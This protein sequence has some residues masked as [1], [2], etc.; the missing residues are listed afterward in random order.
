[1]SHVPLRARLKHLEPDEQD[2]LKDWA[3]NGLGNPASHG[4]YG[5]W[6]FGPRQHGTSHIAACATH[7]LVDRVAAWEHIDALVLTDNIRRYWTLE[8]TA[9]RN[10]DDYGLFLDKQELETKL[11]FL[12][13]DC[14][15]LWVDDLHEDSVDIPFW[16][17]HVLP[18]LERRCKAGKVTIIAT[19]LSPD[20]PKL[21]GLQDV[22][23]NLFVICVAHTPVRE[24]RTV[25]PYDDNA[26]R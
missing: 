15:V 12:W 18:R 14:D 11:D 1:M 20:S 5:L 26:E 17:K 23:E 8:E 22:I 19:T 24:R 25:R 10:A 13:F 4:K 2:V 16:R 21:S 6:I 3:A 9:R 7:R